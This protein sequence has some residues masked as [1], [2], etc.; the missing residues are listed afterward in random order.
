MLRDKIYRLFAGDLDSYTFSYSLSDGVGHCDD[1]RMRSR[2]LDSASG[3]EGSSARELDTRV[4]SDNG[5]V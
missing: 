5:G 1:V 2:L 4:T 3:A